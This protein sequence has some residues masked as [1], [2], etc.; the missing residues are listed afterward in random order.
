MTFTQARE[1][2]EAR[3]RCFLDFVAT[4]G[5]ADAYSALEVLRWVDC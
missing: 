5:A 4:A 2:I 3:G 1:Y